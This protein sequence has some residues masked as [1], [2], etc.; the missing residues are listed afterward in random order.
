MAESVAGAGGTVAVVCPFGIAPARVLADLGIVPDT[1]IAAD[2][3]LAGCGELGLTCDIVIGDLDS[4]DAAELAEAA[5][6]GTEVR[7]F[8]PDKDA[9]DT[10]LAIAAALALDPELLVV[11]GGHGGRI[12]HELGGVA[13]IA[14]AAVPADGPAQ[15]TVWLGADFVAFVCTAT[16][17]FELSAG[18]GA[19]VSLLPIG[20][21]A[22]GVTTSGLRFSLQD[23]T[24]EPYRALGVSNELSDTVA[25]V[26]VA[27]GCLFVIVPMGTGI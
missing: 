16:H 6:A 18:S 22:T 26:S 23:A 13:A 8:P 3:G 14:G 11:I 2:G 7:R 12:D 25:G 15:R 17:P 9:T 24:L 21:P 19:L 20:G 5:A 4:V 10:E 27:G 1:V